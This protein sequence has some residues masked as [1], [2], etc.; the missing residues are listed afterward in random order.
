MI[1]WQDDALVLAARSHGETSLI[2]TLLTRTRGRHAGLVHGGQGSKARPVYQPGNRV[3]ATWRARLADHLGTFGCELIEANAARFLDDADR[4]AALTA[5]AAVSDRALPERE[6]HPDCFEGML[7][8]L[9]A[10]DS[11]FWGQ[12]YVRW[13]IGLLA[14]L[15]FGLDLTACAGGG[16]AGDLG[17]VSPRS[18]RAVSRAMAAPYKDKLLPLP[19]FLIGRGAGDEAEIAE[20]LD[21]TGYFLSRHVFNPQNQDLPAPRRRLRER[22]E[23]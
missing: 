12:A 23:A 16:D 18:G 21:M 1:E 11:E 3:T 2:A 6:P 8:L 4:L 13:E 15:G 10:L 17:Y 19:A 5:A 22:F 7:A 9:A 20:G 14:D